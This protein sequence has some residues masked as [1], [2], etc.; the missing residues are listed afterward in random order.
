MKRRRRHADQFVA[1]ETVRGFRLQSRQVAGDRSRLAAHGV[2]ER[3]PDQQEEQQHDRRVVIGMDG[4]IGGLYDRHGQGQDDAERN[5]H[6]H[7][8]RT[9][10]QRAPGAQEERPAG[11]GRRRQGDQRRGP[12]EEIARLRRD[13]GDVARP[14]RHR[15]QHDVHGG[16]AGD[17]QATQQAAHL[18]RLLLLGT[19]R[20]EWIAVIA[21]ALQRL[22]DLRRHDRAVGPGHMQPAIGEIQPRFGHA[23]QVPHRAFDTR[24]AGATGD[25]FDRQFHAERAVAGRLGI[26]REIERLSHFLTEGSRGSASGTAAGRHD[27][28]RRSNPTAP[29]ALRP[30]RERRRR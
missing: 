24:D 8:E 20:G 9:R 30:A 16:E 11:I 3:A 29:A 26:E 5:R 17:R 27:K 12:M 2:I 7:V 1:H 19:Q 18:G 22:Q 10:A 15:Q 25:T 28:D 13:V 23:R 21:D 14:H 6:I 4:M